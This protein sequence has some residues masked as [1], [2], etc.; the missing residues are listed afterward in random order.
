[1]SSR[2]FSDLRK[3]S[4]RPSTKSWK[5]SR[6]ERATAKLTS[7]SNGGSGK[8][9]SRNGVGHSSDRPMTHCVFVMEPRPEAHRQIILAEQPAGFRTVWQESD[10]SAEVLGKIGDAEFLI[11][12]GITAAQL[13]HARK[14]R[15][16]QMLGVGYDRIDVEEAQKRGI[17][18]A[19]SPDGTS[20]GVAEH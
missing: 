2:R 12:P 3:R 5:R 4:S 15:M 8:P 10:D 11:S 18:V 13:S 17:P 7:R 9:A 20:S 19:I 1:M 14:V 6:P 16:I